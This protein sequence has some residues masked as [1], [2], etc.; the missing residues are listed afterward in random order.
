MPIQFV[1]RTSEEGAVAVS[2]TSLTGGIGNAPIP[3]D[4]VVVALFS[5]NTSDVDLSLP[6]YAEVTDLYV[7]G[8][9][10]T[11]LGVFIKKMGSTPDTSVTLPN[12][13][14][15]IAAI[16][17]LR[18]VDGTTP[19]DVTATTATKTN[20]G[21]PDPAA[22][23]T[24]TDG[25]MILILCATRGSAGSFS[26]PSGYTNAIVKT[27]GSQTVMIASKI[28]TPAGTDNPGT[29]SGI[30]FDQTS[31]TCAS[32]TMALRPG[33]AGGNIKA[34]GTAFA[35]KPVK[36]WNGTAWVTKPLKYWNGTAWVTT[37]Y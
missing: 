29:W 12:L 17:V 26:P 37:K 30:L 6:G 35:A 33:V 15:V 8:T 25:A 3:D 20:S 24:A 18:G 13:P 9:N 11:N 7:N 21:I 22:I 4:L 28:L 36:V 1:G 23:T 16:Y 5:S 14:G 27:N 32:V 31:Y 34:F 19:Q 10:D 2:L